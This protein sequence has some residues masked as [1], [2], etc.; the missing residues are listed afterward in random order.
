MLFNYRISWVLS[1]GLAA[2]AISIGA[3]A[4]NPPK[5][6][7]E[8]EGG[9][10]GN[11]SDG[12]TMRPGAIIYPSMPTVQW[13][14]RAQGMLRDTMS[15]ALLFDNYYLRRKAMVESFES[16]LKAFQGG[17]IGMQPLTYTLLQRAHQ[18]NA[19]FPSRENSA[20]AA[21]G[22]R[23]DEAA[24]VVLF[25]IAQVALRVN[26]HFDTQSYVPYYERY[27]RC[28]PKSSCRRPNR[29]APAFEFGPFYTAYVQSTR[30]VLGEFFAPAY[31]DPAYA[32]RGD[33]LNVMSHDTWELKALLKI[34]DWVLADVNSDVFGRALECLK[35]RLLVVRQRLDDF[36]SNA[37][38]TPFSP[39]IMRRYVKGSLRSTLADLDS[40]V[41]H[42]GRGR[43]GAEQ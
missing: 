10:I 4:D 8:V 19:V 6:P 41:Y 37:S 2:F 3:L 32:G 31:S 29:P 33:V 40:F 16:I 42:D 13:C 25:H 38:K 11:G 28:A 43:C 14:S 20:S 26:A 21:A 36:L 7:K 35:G 9:D 27:V 39:P 17:E 30:L 12:E 24:F 1:A 34:I 18:M 22:E 5:I 15:Y 23:G